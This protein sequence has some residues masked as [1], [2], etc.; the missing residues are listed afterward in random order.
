MHVALLCDRLFITNPLTDHGLLRVVGKLEAELA[1]DVQLASRA[2][3][4]R[5]ERAVERPKV[6]VEVLRVRRRR[7]G[8]DLFRIL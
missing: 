2:V 1:V 4:R 8:G 7:L 6:C 5:F 3:S